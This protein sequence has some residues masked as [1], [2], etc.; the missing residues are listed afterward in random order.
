[1]TNL[2]SLLSSRDPDNNTA[3]KPHF[4]L[5]FSPFL[6]LLHIILIALWHRYFHITHKREHIFFHLLLTSTLIL[7]GSYQPINQGAFSVED[8]EG[9]HSINSLPRRCY[10]PWQSLLTNE[11]EAF[12][13][14]DDRA[15]LELL[16][17]ALV[18][19]PSTSPSSGVQHVHAL[20][21]SLWRS[22]DT[23]F[24]STWTKVTQRKMKPPQEL[25]CQSR[26]GLLSNAIEKQVAKWGRESLTSLPLTIFVNLDSFLSPSKALV[27]L[28]EKWRK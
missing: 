21:H 4:P 24:T 28:N 20:T 9:H 27:S 15:T 18:C 5:I 16:L 19:G 13:D 2:S 23:Y 26:R 11:K 17:R 25:C 12:H 7:L 6:S 8:G 10:Y 3:F 1:M 22:Y 14:L